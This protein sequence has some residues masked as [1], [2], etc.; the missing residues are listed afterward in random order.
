MLDEMTTMWKAAK[1][2]A[3][4]AAYAQGAPME[5]SRDGPGIGAA[6]A[7]T[8][9]L[10]PAQIQALNE[11]LQAAYRN[12]AA[13]EAQ[14]TK[15]TKGEDGTMHVVIDSFEMEGKTF[16]ERLHS[17]M[18]A[19]L[20]LKQQELAR[21]HLDP[22][23]NQLFLSFGASPMKIDLSKEDSGFQYRIKSGS[24]TISGSDGELPDFL[25]RF[26]TE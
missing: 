5:V 24:G 25:R 19:L 16:Q 10:Q 21:M 7:K 15:R 6:T 8:L 23:V 13:L 1:S 9:D 11:S 26:W 14:H 22:W 3:G 18:D 2:G 4:H 12:Y 20:T 17:Q